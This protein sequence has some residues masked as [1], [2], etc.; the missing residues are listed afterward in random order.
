MSATEAQPI[1]ESAEPNVEPG[2]EPEQE[3]EHNEELNVEQAAKPKRAPRKRKAAEESDGQPKA[4]RA[5][6]SGKASAKA[7]GKSAK[8]DGQ[9]SGKSSGKASTKSSAKPAA[10]P[11]A[12][13]AAK[14]TA[15]P[16]AKPT[17]K[18]TATP[19]DPAKPDEK[20]AHT[21]K[22]ANSNPKGH[23]AARRK[24]QERLDST[25]L[26]F[27]NSIDP[28]GNVKVTKRLNRKT[29]EEDG[30]RV[31]AYGQSVCEHELRF[32]TQKFGTTPA[33]PTKRKSGYMN[34]TKVM[35]AEWAK[36]PKYT[37]VDK[38]NPNGSK[39]IVSDIAKK[40]K[41]LGEED[42]VRYTNMSDEELASRIAAV[43]EPSVSM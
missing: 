13:P 12:K 1:Q 11:T 18:P 28:T 14:T 5:K 23:E 33:Q 26:K 43:V 27:V 42:K 29:V 6:P 35:R 15:K 36:N 32:L 10:K 38:T 34:F 22:S 25:F 37:N 9:P 20:P 19:A 24:K 39:T 2:A 4:Q 31:L 3:Q 41:S 8:A 21:V 17:V 40:W 16:I 30:V 7:S